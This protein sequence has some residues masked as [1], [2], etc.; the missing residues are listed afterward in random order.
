MSRRWAT[1]VRRLRLRRGVGWAREEVV[2]GWGK[3]EVRAV[4]VCGILM[5]VCGVETDG[6]LDR[7]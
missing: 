7:I 4:C 1:S 3:G 5:D 6:V 2:D